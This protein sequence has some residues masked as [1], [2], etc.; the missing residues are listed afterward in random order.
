[1]SDLTPQPSS[2]YRKAM[3]HIMADPHFSKP[4]EDWGKFYGYINAKGLQTLWVELPVPLL[5]ETT[6]RLSGR[7][8]V[9]RETP[10][11]ADAHY[12]GLCDIGH[13]C[14]AAVRVS[15]VR[16][17]LFK[18]QAHMPPDAKAAVA[19]MLNVS[20]DLLEVYWIE[21][22]GQEILLLEGRQVSPVKGAVNMA[23]DKLFQIIY[24]STAAR[25]FE[26]ADLLGFLQRT[27]E[28]Y[29]QAGITGMLLYKDGQLMQVLEG[30]ERVVKETF[31]RISQRP[32]HYGIMVLVKEH[33]QQRQFADWSM[34]FPNPN[35]PE[36]Q[37]VPGYS[38]F[39]NT[40]QTDTDLN[41]IQSRYDR[42][43][44][45]FKQNIR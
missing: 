28:C 29:A 17:H 3:G 45:L 25:L 19:N 37:S 1:M 12:H 11:G 20:P 22:N 23:E 9:Q 21:E 14:E 43:L 6:S 44:H 34:A 35:F 38:N 10:P 40:P 32:D 5:A 30:P 39:L 4:P 7:L 13:G 24:V 42:L 26:P 36:G 18:L 41:S 15:R 33:I 27:R 2:D 16:P 31:S 8:S